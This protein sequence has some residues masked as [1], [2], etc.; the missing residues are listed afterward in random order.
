[1]TG[2]VPNLSSAR[3]YYVELGF[4]TLPLLP[5]TKQAIL[6]AWQSRSP[7]DMWRNAPENANLGIRCGGSTNLAVIDCDEKEK[8]GTFENIVRFMSGLGYVSGSYPVVQ[9]A[10]EIGRH[11]Y[12]NLTST[13]KGNYTSLTPEIGAGEFRFGSGAY[14]VAPPSI[15]NES[16]IYSLIYGDF[17]HLPSI[18][19]SDIS[20]VLREPLV[21]N[22]TCKNLHISRYAWKLLCGDIPTHYPSRSEAEQA[23][24]LSLINLDWDFDNILSLFIK[25]PGPGKFKELYYQNPQ[26]A[27][28]YLRHSYI[29]AKEHAQSNISRGRQIAINAQQ[30]A[31]SRPWKG[32]TGAYDRAVYLA[33]TQNAYKCGKIIYAASSRDLGEIANISHM[34]ATNATKRLI[35]AGFIKLEEKAVANLANM[36]SLQGDFTHFQNPHINL[37]NHKS[38][39]DIFSYFGLGKS[40]ELIW[41]QLSHGPKTFDELVQRTGKTKLTVTKWLEEMS[42]I[43]DTK[44]GEVYSIVY[45]EGENWHANP[46]INLDTIAEML[47]VAGTNE[48]RKRVHRLQR[49]IHNSALERGRLISGDS[50]GV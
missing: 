30:W 13:P 38:S 12:V 50:G 8:P 4:E 49:E 1:M 35:K 31:L 23:L 40:S 2:F 14:V 48:R 15:V 45:L 25:Y 28:G 36:Y 37:K 41:E 22:K 24:L 46:D 39:H 9:T 34:A 33:H 26:K 7:L 18:K 3:Q 17:S 21:E 10:S 6:K 32:R 44:T 20:I 29:K 47:G 42:N 5:G 19:Y 16:G 11:I 27:I 43:V